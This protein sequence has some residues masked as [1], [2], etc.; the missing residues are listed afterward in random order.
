MDGLKG[1]GRRAGTGADAALGAAMAMAITLNALLHAK[2]D[3]SWLF[4]LG[5]GI[6]ICAA[7]LLRGRNR[8][9]AVT[10]GLILFAVAGLAVA[11]GTM[12]PVGP[13]FGGGL[14]GLAVLGGAAARTLPARQAVIIGATGTVLIAASETA[15]PDGLF[16]HRALYAL[17]GATF[18]FAALGVGLYLRYLDFL[19]HERLKAVRQDER[20]D[21]ARELHDVV[22]HHVT[23]IV[24]QAQAARFTGGDHPERLTMAL[25]SIEGAGL[26]TLAALR[27]LV[28]LL[29]DTSDAPAR[30]PGPEP[31]S[32]LVERFAEH[33]PAVELRLPDGLPAASWPP[34]VASTVYRIVQEAL[35]NI[36]RHAPDARRVAVTVTS[37]LAQVRV[38]IT[39]DAPGPASRTK[40]SSRP[41]GGYGL[42]GMRERVE[43]LGGM[44]RAGPRPEAG[45]AVQASLP[46]PGPP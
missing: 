30:T 7:A 36:A 16:D 27:Q 33:G 12:P 21:L 32:R 22:A 45:W 10:S 18:W 29:R 28:G 39:D 44:L 8:A 5:V 4:G 3:L 11:F 6:V 19:H 37:D 24:V 38:E 40:P 17:S 43:A 13:F 14:V 15:G 31:I 35:T 23:G 26:D 2:A 46:V 34:E 20:L 9:R 42:T 25:G 1:L 41:A